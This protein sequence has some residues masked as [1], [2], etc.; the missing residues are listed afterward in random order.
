MTS[1]ALPALRLAAL[2]LVGLL[3]IGGDAAAQQKPADAGEQRQGGLLGMLPETASSRRTIAIEGKP[4]AYRVEA[5]TLPLRDGQGHETA[6][7]FSVAYMADPA[8]RSRP[9]TFVFNG[10]PGAAATY[11]HLGGLG[12]R[13]FATAQD[14][15]MLAP[16][17][18]LVDNP[19][20]WLA[21]TDLVFVD[22][23]GT[24]YS[25]AADPAKEADFWGVEQDASA[26]SAFMR[27]YLQTSGRRLSPIYLVGESYGGFRVAL[28]ARRLQGESG[29]APSGVVMISPALEFSLLG[30]NDDFQPL[31]WALS[32]PAMAAVRLVG[33][34]VTGREALA[35]RLKP[36]EDFALKDYLA[37]L[38]SGLE[39]GSRIAGL[40]VAALTGLPQSLVDRHFARIPVS[41]FLKEAARARGQVLSR[42]DGTIGA[43][44]PE[45]QSSRPSG[46]DPVLDR[47]GTALTATFVS[48]VRDEVGYR[49][50]VTYRVLNGEVN[51]RW[52]YGTSPS[53]Q[54]YAGSVGELQEARSLNPSMRILIAQ[55]FTDLATPYL[56]A[57]YLVSQLPPMPGAVPI[58]VEVYAGGHMMYLRPESRRALRLDAEA[59]YSALPSPVSAG[60]TL[61]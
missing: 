12:P 15:D 49:T 36:V 51:R 11:L 61:P 6:A 57:R 4:L 16:P 58:R 50:D 46:P 33:E 32:L 22:P 56:A 3:A 42:Y 34:G 37:A 38:A 10:G 18:R 23:V 27:L 40:Q 21:W 44:D 53:R 13:I 29:I 52:D 41:V 59:I 54:G 7:I 28:L 25:R 5:S 55:G 14:G 20:T 45:P 47:V 9:I 30:G 19:D 8:D 35:S 31:Q 48:Y 43:P 24:G 2:L 60:P 26:M 17:P 39:A 1:R